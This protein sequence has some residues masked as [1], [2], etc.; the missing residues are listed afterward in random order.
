MKLLYR[1][2]GRHALP[3]RHIFN[4][5]Y[6]TTFVSHMWLITG[7][8]EFTIFTIFTVTVLFFPVFIP[9]SGLHFRALQLLLMIVFYASVSLELTNKVNVNKLPNVY[10]KKSQINKR[11]SFPCNNFSFIRNMLLQDNPLRR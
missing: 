9:Q 1:E 10:S 4:R 11:D 8:T 6:F 2:I 3:T 5:M 7:T